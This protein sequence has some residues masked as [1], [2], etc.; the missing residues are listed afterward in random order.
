VRSSEGQSGRREGV[1]H[2]G[3]WDRDL[4]L[5]SGDFGGVNMFQNAVSCV[6][7]GRRFWWFGFM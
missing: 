6:R 4:S 5:A 3:L 7:E 1:G 2:A